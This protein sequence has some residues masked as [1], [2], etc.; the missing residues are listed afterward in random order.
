MSEIIRK[1]N[2]EKVLAMANTFIASFKELAEKDKL[3]ESCTPMELTLAAMIAGE[4]FTGG[5]RLPSG[6]KMDEIK[7]SYLQFVGQCKK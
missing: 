5:F 6:I 3:P 2:D 4:S 7:A 1:I